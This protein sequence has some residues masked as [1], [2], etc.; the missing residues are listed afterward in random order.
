[1]DAHAPQVVITGPTAS[2]KESLALELA[3]RWGGEIVSLDSMKVFREIDI[4]TAK[5]SAAARA[6]IVHHM[7]DIVDPHED[8]STGQYLELLEETLSGVRART[9]AILSGGTALYLKGFLDGF[10]PAP[11]ADWELRRSLQGIAESEG[12]EALYRRLED[13]DPAAAATINRNDLRRVIRALELNAS[14]GRSASEGRNWGTGAK[15]ER[16]YPVRLFGIERE[17]AAL[18]ERIDRRVHRMVEAG[19]IEEARRLAERQPALSRT[20]AQSIGVKEVMAGRSVE[21]IVETVQ[22]ESRRFAKRQLTWFRKMDIEWID[23]GGE[24][25]R[26]WADEVERRMG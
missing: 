17:R 13:Q 23:A 5:P 19:L 7:I 10:R 22:R 4:A 18:Y 2:G 9:R 20:A 25:P 12:I 15:P 1:M 26:E 8:F 16:A 21:E 6:R 14:T 24:D 11:P 3:E